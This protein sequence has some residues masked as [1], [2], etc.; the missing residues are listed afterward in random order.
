MNE[1]Q[2]K[3]KY[4]QLKK[5]MREMEYMMGAEGTE[6]EDRVFPEKDPMTPDVD[7][8]E[9][10]NMFTG[11][12]DYTDVQV[13]SIDHKKL[14]KKWAEM[15]LYDQW[16][17]SLLEAG[18]SEDTQTIEDE[19]EEEMTEDVKLLQANNKKMFKDIKKFHKERAG[20]IADLKEYRKR[21][22]EQDEEKPEDKEEKP[23]EDKKKEESVKIVL[24]KLTE[25]SPV[26]YRSNE[27]Y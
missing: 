8:G 25:S 21:L 15:N 7:S 23:K 6:G 2:M 22:T 12:I 26:R 16:K 24:P 4:A 27:P 20:M 14:Q 9:G 5:Q 3:M 18:D 13:E 17:K 11:D 19:E 10:E 1:K